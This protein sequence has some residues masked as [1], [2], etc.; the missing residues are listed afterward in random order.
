MI[1][2]ISRAQ[3]IAD[4]IVAAVLLLLAIWAAS[5]ESP[6]VGPIV[7]VLMCA[8]LAVRRLA[9]ALALAGVWAVSVF[10]LTRRVKSLDR[11]K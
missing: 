8:S 7:A 10:V 5:A 3:L 4:V 6:L 11:L 9:P 1:R 2:S